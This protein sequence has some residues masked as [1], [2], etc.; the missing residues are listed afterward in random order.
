MRS[1]RSGRKRVSRGLGGA[2]LGSTCVLAAACGSA[3]P[4]TF[5]PAGGTSA[6]TSNSPTSAPT[7]SGAA[8]TTKLTVPPFGK[9]VHIAMTSWLPASSSQIPA[10][11]AAKDFLLAVL[12]ADYTGNRDHRWTT[13]VPAGPARTGLARSLAVPG[14]THESFIGTIRLWRM[15]A[16]GAPGPKGSIVVT[17]CVDSARARNTGLHSGKVLPKSLQNTVDQNYYLNSDVLAKDSTGNWQVISISPAVYY[18]QAQEC[19]P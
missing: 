4:Q 17:E 13:Y 8:T 18:P 7:A 16:L 14:V 19:K 12:Y 11:V 9:N 10:V 2:L 1:L 5:H 3:T 15:H 6:S